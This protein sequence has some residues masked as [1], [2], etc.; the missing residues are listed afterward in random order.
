MQY[1]IRSRCVARGHE[2]SPAMGR[3][4]NRGARAARA[5]RGVEA[6][7]RRSAGARDWRVFEVLAQ[8]R[9]AAAA[10]GEPLGEAVRHHLILGVIAR[11]AAAP[12][13]DG[14]VLRGGVLTRAWIAP[15]RRPARDLDYVGDFPFDVDATARRLLPAL[16]APRPGGDDDGVRIDAAGAA[17]RGIWLETAFPGVRVELAIGLGRPDQRLSIDVGFGDPLIPPA[18]EIDLADARADG[19]TGEWADARDDG[20]ADARAGGSS[21]GAVRVRAVRPET[22]L[23][24]KLHSLAEL[25]P[26]WRPKDLADLWAIATHVPLDPAALRCAIAA[27]FESRGMPAAAAAA[28]LAAPHWATKTDRVRWAARPRDGVPDLAQTLA[29]VRAR[30]APV[31]EP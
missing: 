21:G 5:K 8:L 18:A 11:V 4:D 14:F 13:G 2:G 24:W 7:A 3:R 12:G 31:L 30:L 29:H 25:G 15:L 17:V 19:R 20:Q 9:A 10:R 28:V 26:S 1:T 22:Q 27:A 16:A 6:L 23:A